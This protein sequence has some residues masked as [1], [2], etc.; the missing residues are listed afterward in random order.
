MSPSRPI[1][2][3]KNCLSPSVCSLFPLFV[4]P[5]YCSPL[6]LSCPSF[7]PLTMTSA[8]PPSLKRDSTRSL[9][10]QFTTIFDPA[11]SIASYRAHSVEEVQHALPL[12]FESD[13]LMQL[14]TLV[15]STAALVSADE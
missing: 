10:D 3:Y 6:P 12:P 9:C 11:D 1:C 7:T 13:N 4:C 14:R 15:K 5:L 2:Q 8:Y